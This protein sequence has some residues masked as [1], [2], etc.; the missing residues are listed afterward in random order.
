MSGRLSN[1]GLS[2]MHKVMAGYVTR[3]EIPGLVTL[4]NQGEDVHVDAMGTVA[5]G[6]NSRVQRDTIF[7][8]ASLT[9]PVTAVATMILV[10]E[11][12]VRLDETV[13]RLLP[14][15]ANRNV[16]R[17]LDGPLDDTVSAKRAV[18]VRDLTWGVGV[19]YAPPDAYPILKAANELQI[20]VGPPQPLKTPPPDEWMRRLSTLPLMS[21]PGEMWIYNTGSDVLGVLIARA[22]EAFLRERIFEPLGMKDTSFSVP[23]DKLNRFAT[24]YW[25]SFQ[26]GKLEVYDEAATGQWTQPPAFPSGSGGLVSTAD[27]YFAFSRMM[28]NK[29]K[30]NGVRMLSGS[31]LETMTT[32]QLTPQQKAVSGLIP[33]YF[34]S[35]GWGFGVSIVTRRISPA[36]PVDMYGWNGG[37]G[38]LWNT[39]PK[40]DSAG[41]LLTQRAWTSAR[42]PDVCQDFGTLVYGAG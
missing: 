4:V 11:C 35:H 30:H 5:I 3:G 34:D 6:R 19:L 26:T 9:K 15:L 8:I 16:L 28:V 18:T 2:R 40:N 42:P 38:T 12:K 23:P 13:D 25:N 33:G 17:R 37:L 1:A 29:G 22:L 39:D 27:D 14:E 10:E 24:A 31:F 20:G 36:E 32:D 7:R 41:I 21:Q